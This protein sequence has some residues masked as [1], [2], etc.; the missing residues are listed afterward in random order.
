VSTASVARTDFRSIRRSYIVVGVVGVFVAVVALAFVGSSEVHPHP[1][2][3]LWGF[4]AIVAWFYPL[5]AAPLAYMAVAGDRVRGS[6]RYYLG[7][8]STR[9]EYYLG[10]YLTRAAVAV[11]AVVL[12]VAV[13]FVVAA[14]TYDHAPDP[15]RF[16]TFGALSTLY[17]LGMFG[18]FFAISAATASRSRAMIGSLG[19]Y[20]VLALFWVG[21]LPAVNVNTLLATVESLPGVTISDAAELIVSALAPGGAYFNSTQL[22]WDGVLG[23]YDV[24]APLRGSPD[25]LGLKPWFNVVLLGVWAV[26]A[27]LVGYLRFRSAE[28]G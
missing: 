14:A 22:V 5:F 11:A 26:G 17:A 15:G 13:A 27:P 10:K 3:T 6:A 8:P 7:L 18:T 12:A 1:Y 19:A 24:F 4:T 16:L 20:F 2:R 23:E 9:A 28:L 25:Y 21:P